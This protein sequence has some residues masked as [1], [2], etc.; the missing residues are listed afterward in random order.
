MAY[1]HCYAAERGMPVTTDQ[2]SRPSRRVALVIGNA[3]YGS[4]QLKNPIN[5]ARAVANELQG[6]N[7]EVDLGENLDYRGIRRKI[8]EFGRKIDMGGVGLF[9]YAGHGVQ[10]D[11]ENYLIPL[12]ARIKHEEEVPAEAVAL[13][14]LMRRMAGA[15]NKLNI[16]IL[17]AC[18]DNPY[19][20]RFRSLRQGL[21][22]VVAPKG[23][24]IA[25]STAPG[26]TARDGDGPNS[27]FTEALVKHLAQP[28]MNLERLMKAVGRD[29]DLKTGGE[30]RPW[31][32][33]NYYGDFYF[34]L[35]EKKSFHSELPNGTGLPRLKIGRGDQRELQVQKLL[36]QAR[37]DIIANRLT[38]PIGNN[39]YEKYRK[40]LKVA[41]KNRDAHA[42][43]QAIVGRYVDLAKE[44]IDS[45]DFENA[46]GFLKRAQGISATDNRVLAAWD[47]LKA[48]R[49]RADI[50]RIIHGKASQNTPMA[51]PVKQNAVSRH[52]KIRVKVE[53]GHW[54][55][56]NAFGAQ[57]WIPPKFEYR[58]VPND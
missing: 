52:K 16:I 31:M 6:L 20:R 9:Y 8:V 28:D 25:Y 58:I 50:N 23:T 5:D 3:N 48:A 19:E 29:V 7:F 43:M 47:E 1:G 18:R 45:Q 27:P 30:Q 44:R 38:S 26:R 10:V 32:A 13:S 41:P 51:K 15:K 55:K 21:A 42:G 37:E 56:G 35:G 12:G 11:G 34:R 57:V 33:S 36:K 49:K 39:A 24:F 17:D 4:G 2:V 54:E 22:H 53:D 40:V 46:V 14:Y